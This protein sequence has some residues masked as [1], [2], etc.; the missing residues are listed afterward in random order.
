[1]AMDGDS[2]AEKPCLTADVPPVFLPNCGRIFIR[3]KPH[4]PRTEQANFD[5]IKRFIHFHGKRHP[6]GV[7]ACLM[8]P[9]QMF[10]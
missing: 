10:D 8:R 6:P 1:M 2:G 3:V 9:D 7:E 5:W 4:S